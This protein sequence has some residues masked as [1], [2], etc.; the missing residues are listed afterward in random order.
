[1]VKYGGVFPVELLVCCNYT[2]FGFEELLCVRAENGLDLEAA[3]AAAFVIV[4]GKLA[5]DIA[6]SACGGRVSQ[7]PDIQASVMV[8]YEIASPPPLISYRKALKGC[9]LRA[10]GV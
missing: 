9:H 4:N 1:M 10:V 5:D 6:E 8:E 7:F 3:T 2:A